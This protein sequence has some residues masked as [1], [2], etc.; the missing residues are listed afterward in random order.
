MNRFTR[1][2]LAR[3]DGAG[4]AEGVRAV[5][6]ARPHRRLRPDLP[7]GLRR[8]A[9][10]PINFGYV[11]CDACAR[12]CPV[13]ALEVR[14]DEIVVAGTCVGCGRCAAE[15]GTGALRLEGFDVAAALPAGNGAVR[16]ECSK[17]SDASAGDAL[18]VPCIQGVPV[19]QWLE[20]THAAAGR[21][22]EVIDRGWCS[23]C[24][25][26]GIESGD[27]LA[28]ARVL[29]EGTGLAAGC[30]PRR[31]EIPL[32][33]AA[34]QPPREAQP[35]QPMSRRGFFARISRGATA[36]VT[37]AANAEEAP[38]ARAPR[39]GTLA[40]PERARRVAALRSL[41]ARTG[42]A[43]PA[44]L[45]PALHA[46]GAC[47]DQG[48][49]A[50]LCPTGALRRYDGDAE[51]GIE[52]EA[53]ACVECGSCVAAC[54]RKA[55]ALRSRG[56]ESRDGRQRLTRHRRRE[57][58]ECGSPTSEADGW[59]RACRGR[60]E[61]AEEAAAELHQSMKPQPRTGGGVR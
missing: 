10:L 39:P 53:A 27:S 3:A 60:A 9:C 22:I 17:V 52:F 59:C 32:P 25:A 20:L 2:A 35:A 40:A 4:L 41:A 29:L 18:R 47:R 54:G 43:L 13:A 50:A 1:G 23:R 42:S 44:G 28:R 26:G 19:S 34:M 36:A 12:A 5:N 33:A 15:C 45:F 21:T 46:S 11:R 61:L 8:D 55:L 7:L 38:P 48:V 31:I 24:V 49:C 57:C 56:V 14:A 6:V 37:T 51:T 30:L 58:R 16:V